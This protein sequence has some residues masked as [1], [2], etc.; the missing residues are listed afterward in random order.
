MQEITKEKRIE[1]TS[2]KIK[3]LFEEL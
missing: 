1:N 3:E 2:K